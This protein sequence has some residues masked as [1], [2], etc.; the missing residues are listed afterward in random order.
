MS[1]M[2]LTLRRVQRLRHAHPLELF[3]L[4]FQLIKARETSPLWEC[5]RREDLFS[6]LRHRQGW[7]PSMILY[8]FDSQIL[9]SV[10]CRD[11][12]WRSG[13]ISFALMRRDIWHIST[14]HFRDR[15]WRLHLDFTDSTI[16]REAQSNRVSI[17]S[18]MF[19]IMELFHISVNGYQN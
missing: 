4:Q 6:F 9:L 2:S 13:S 17:I 11:L 14:I 15:R 19:Y 7:F 8:L 1:R 3:L 16:R 18:A 5:Q 10:L 12:I